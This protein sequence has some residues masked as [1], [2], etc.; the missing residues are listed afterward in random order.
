VNVPDCIKLIITNDG[1][2]WPAVESVANLASRGRF[3]AGAIEKLSGD[4]TERSF[5]GWAIF[6]LLGKRSFDAQRIAKR[7]VFVG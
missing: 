2:G 6:A 1:L 7:L 5:G 3:L 4:I